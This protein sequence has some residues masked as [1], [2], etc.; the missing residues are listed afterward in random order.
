[1]STPNTTLYLLSGVP[2]DNTYTDTIYFATATA[3]YDYFYGKKSKTFANLSYQRVGEN[4]IRV[5]ASADDLY[6]C[7]YLM[8]QNTGFGN[9]WF[10]AFITETPK[11]INDN[12]TEIV[13]EIDV[14]Q[15]YFFDAVL[16][17]SYIIRQH[18]ATD[19]AGDNTLP[20]PVDVGDIKSYYEDSVIFNSYDVVVAHVHG[21]VS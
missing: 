10:Y 14:M 19:V 18:Q 11:Y 2:L 16:K 1:M 4:R 5:Q 15:T 17:P 3:Q 9:K 6:N 20:E 12:T 13:Y 21:G 7:N 8:F